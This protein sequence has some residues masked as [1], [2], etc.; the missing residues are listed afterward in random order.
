[1]FIG[2]KITVLHGQIHSLCLSYSAPLS[3]ASIL[4][5]LSERVGSQCGFLFNMVLLSQTVGGRQI[6][7][8]TNSHVMLL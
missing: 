7:Q 4:C 6:A 5:N 1:M 8:N 2:V 3:L